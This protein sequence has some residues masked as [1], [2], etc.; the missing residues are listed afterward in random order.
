MLNAASII[1]LLLSNTIDSVEPEID[2]FLLEMIVSMADLLIE[3]FA[4]ITAL[5]VGDIEMN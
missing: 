3:I 2:E 5:T 4:F 1:K